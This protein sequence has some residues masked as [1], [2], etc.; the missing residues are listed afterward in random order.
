MSV[1]ALV[2]ARGGSKGVPRKN[3]APIGG[4]PLIA[5]TIEAAHATGVVDQVLVSTDDA[6]IAEVARRFGA[7]VPWLRPAE[8]ALDDTP[9]LAVAM[10]ALDAC[11]DKGIEPNWV[12]LLQ[13]T[14]PLR[15]PSDIAGALA[16]A[17]E[18]NSN[19]VIGVSETHAHPAW[20]FRMDGEA[21]LEPLQ[22]D[23]AATHR[24]GREVLYVP[25]GA[26]YLVKSSVLRS[27]GSWYGPGARGWVMP[28]ERSLDID[29]GFDLH[30]ARL[31]LEERIT[32]KAS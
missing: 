25:N 32:V 18:T 20:M 27:G 19:S 29:T 16:L 2:P 31:L 3:L 28:V 7:E 23:S 21:Y 4:K 15:L 22:Q 12:F 14:S 26:L 13:P 6:E 10:H 11:A 24:Q 5:W 8:L 1:L 9:T 30:L 17:R